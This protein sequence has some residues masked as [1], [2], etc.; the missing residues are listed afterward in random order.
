MGMMRHEDLV[1]TSRALD[2]AHVALLQG[3]YEHALAI[4]RPLCWQ[5][6]NSDSIR[7]L[8]GLAL[9]RSRHDRE[10]RRQLAVLVGK[11]PTNHWAHYALAVVLQRLGRQVDARGHARLARAMCPSNERYRRLTQQLTA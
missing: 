6:P 8:F 10:A 7:E 2:T 4:L 1:D 9:L 5:H 3:R 11:D